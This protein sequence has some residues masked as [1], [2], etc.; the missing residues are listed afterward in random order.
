M[1]ERE[2]FRFLEATA[3]AAF[4]VDPLGFIRS[5]NRSA[6]RLF[7][8]KSSEVLERPCAELFQGRGALGT[9]V[10][11]ESCDVLECAAA[12][13]EIPNYDLEVKSRSGKGQWVNVSILVFADERT[14]RRLV[15]HLARDITERKKTETLTQQLVQAAKQLAA[16]SEDP[17]PPA[18]VSP[19]TEQEKCVLRMLA[20]GKNPAEVAR[21]LRITPRTLRN[22]ISHAN[23]KLRTRNRL[24]A[25][26]HATRRRLI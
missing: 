19:L 5:W 26:V 14:G 25:V 13:R 23:R 11:T 17:A 20:Q 24:E 8:Y 3:D 2:L 16:H 12:G 1:L 18:P 6:E 9:L 4:A 10:C 22:H 7:G 15:V 21:D